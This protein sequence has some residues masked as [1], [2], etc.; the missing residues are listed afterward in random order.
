MKKLFLLLMGVVF[1]A[2]QALAQRTV[3]GKVTDEKGLPIANASVIVKGTTNGV[4]TK[5]DGTFS[6]TF[7]SGKTLVISSVDMTTVEKSIGNASSLNISMKQEDK[8]LQ[9]VIVVG[10]GSG[11]KQTEMV[12]SVDIV[13]AKKIQ[14][15]P[16]ANVL[17]ALQGQVSGLQIFSSS[18]EPSATPSLR[19]NGVGSLTAGTT[20]LFV[21]DGIPLSSGTLVSMNPEDFESVTVLKDASATSIYGSRAANGVI[22]LTTKKGKANAPQINVEGQYSVSNLTKNTNDFFNRFMNTQQLTGFWK[23]V[24]YQTQAQIDATLATAKYKGVDTKW[25]D[26]YYKNDIPAYQVNVNMSGGGGKTTY[27]V[28]GGYFKQEGL[29]FR[30]NFKR[31]TLRSNITSVVNNWL[32]MALNLSGG[33]DVRQT[34]PYGSNST[35]RGLGLLAQPFWSANDSTGKELEFITGWGRYHPNYLARKVLS[36]S[37]NLQFNP[38]GYVQITPI[39][40]LILKTQVGM[41]A[42]DFNTTAV[43]LPSYL[44]SLNNGNAS[45]SITREVLKTITNTI[46]YKFSVK[47]NHGVTLLA[48]QE[49][50]K[51]KLKSFSGSS[52]GQTDDR[53]V[54]VS[55]GPN[56]RNSSSSISEYAF[57]SYFGRI[58]YDYKKKY[59]LDLSLRQDESSRFGRDNRTA[60]FWSVGARWNA[61]QEKFLENINWLTDLV[62]RASIGTS[63][64]SSIGNY[65][66]LGLVGTNQ[67]DGQP[68]FAFNTAG[69]PDLSWEQQK[70]TNIGVNFTLFKRANFEVEYYNKL[71]SNM[72][73][74]VPFPY[75][76]GFSDVQSNVGTLKNSGFNVTI[77]GDI[78][79]KK[80]GYITPY[81][82]FNYNKQKVTELFQGRNYWIIPNT[83]VCWVVGQPVS[84]FYPV[85]DKVDPVTGNPV[86]FQP[87]SDPNLIVN[88]Q[89]DPTKVTSTFST[90]ALQQNTNIKRY[91]PFA[92]GFGLNAGWKG[93]S[94]QTDFS[95]VS[96]KY[97]INNDRYFFENPNQFPGFNQST[98]ILNYWKKAG[99][100]AQF[101]K[102]GT[103]FTQFDSRLI[104]NASFVRMKNIT[105]GYNVPKKILAKTKFING[106]RAYITGRN[107]LTFTK[108]SGP[109]PEVDTNV[110]LGANPN[111]KQIAFGLDFQL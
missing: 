77:N 6:I 81:V 97:M 16:S 82:N 52:A 25:Q 55:S 61:K 104:E 80:D 62:V 14:D 103:Q 85:F 64:N 13:N 63:G 60:N 95:F 67:Y 7:P 111:T 108:Y 110:S 73:L 45:E 26:I 83:G 57:H 101:P 79:R 20:P 54:T 59:F 36:T 21:I 96:G 98:T 86:W 12:G 65:D 43:Q 33:Y 94:L 72:L 17:D 71:T 102:Y 40:D 19:L 32:S 78:I 105:V 74:N 31:Y 49:Y 68:G 10:Y 99:D 92:G 48:G 50:I 53:L 34:N 3:T 30:S 41:E 38:T 109:D 28:S 42:Y 5:A 69:N 4:V 76:S 70:L 89:Q 24:G 23:E 107:L 1:F 56:N 84:Y 91:A 22:Y 39:K 100:V 29:T 37:E 15:R 44:G 8:S 87:N 90:G 2:F 27:Y 35:N 51:D 106:V 58:N 75:T 9:E 11:K 18:G 66:A 88:N 46:E 47:S 93:F